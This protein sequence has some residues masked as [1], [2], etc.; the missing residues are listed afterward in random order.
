MLELWNEQISALF[1][2]NQKI[3]VRKALLITVILLVKVT[4]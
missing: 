3:T 1:Q 2:K 4:K